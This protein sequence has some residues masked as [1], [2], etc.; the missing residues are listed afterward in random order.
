MMENA[1]RA[2]AQ[3]LMERL[4]V[5]GKRVLVL[6]GRATTGG[7]S[8]LRPRSGSGWSRCHLFFC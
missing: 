6:M 3:T 1:G 7:R 8:G 2:N 5:Q 4:L